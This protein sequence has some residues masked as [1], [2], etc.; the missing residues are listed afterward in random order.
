[1]RRD[2][3]FGILIAIAM[4][5]A[6]GALKWAFDANAS[7]R[8]IEKQLESRKDAEQ[9][10]AIGDNLRYNQWLHWQIDILRHQQGLPPTQ[11]P[12]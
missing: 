1:M 8:V 6:G 10:K 12:K 7:L 3:L 11:F 9:D 4:A 2:A 5:L